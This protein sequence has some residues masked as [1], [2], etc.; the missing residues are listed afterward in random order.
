MSLQSLG[1]VLVHPPLK[2][3]LRVDTRAGKK[4]KFAGVK[5]K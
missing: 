5:K 4:E 2:L 3:I 1:P